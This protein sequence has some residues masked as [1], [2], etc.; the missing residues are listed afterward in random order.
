MGVSIL[1]I[2][3]GGMKGIISSIVLM[4]L[5]KYL[6]FYSRNESAH[7]TDYFD[8]IAGT[9]TGSILTALLLCPDE[10]GKPKYSA[11]DTLDLYLSKGKS[12]FKKRTLYPI[13]TFFGLFGS[14]YT[15]EA[16]QNELIN[17]FQDM[18][19]S[20]LLKPCIIV[21]YDLASSRTIFFNAMSSQ[22][23]KDRD[24]K[25]VDAVLASCSTPTYFPPV[26]TMFHERC[27]DCLIDGGVSANN[28]AMSAL[29]EALKLPQA[30]ELHDTTL[31]SIGNV[32]VM[33]THTCDEVKNWGLVKYAIPIFQT[34]MESSEEIVHYQLYKIYE[35]LH[36][37][38]QYQRIEALSDEPV[39]AMDDTSKEALQKFVA[40]GNKL[41][42]REELTIRSFAKHLVETKGMKK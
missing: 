15:N 17:Y 33:K 3:G 24:V 35:S 22:K 20:Q 4:R 26:C 9:S 18:K 1:S 25:V 39:P 10:N 11:S 23:H 13:N 31:L 40:I 38:N 14:K 16:F 30:N 42:D 32:T 28:P 21:S 34:V 41:A 8:L 29:I 27:I 6:K 7:I 12:M 5:E 36:I 19:I 2:D 37:K